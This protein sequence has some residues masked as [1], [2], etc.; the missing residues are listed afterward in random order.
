MEVPLSTG[1]KV[2]LREKKG[3]HHFIERNLLASCMGQGGQNMGG[4]L[5]TM[6]IQTVVGIAAIDGD[7]VN[8]PLTLAEVYELM[9]NFTYDEWAELETKSMPKAVQDK[10]AELA[11]NS[12]TSPGSETVSN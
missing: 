6:T 10:M 5:T 12:Q 4:I 3:Q 2:T 1:K 8:T 7:V 9:N 11:K